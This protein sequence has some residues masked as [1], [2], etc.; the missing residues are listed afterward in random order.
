MNNRCAELVEQICPDELSGSDSCQLLP[1]FRI[2]HCVLVLLSLPLS[3][4]PSPSLSVSL[5]V[6]MRGRHGWV[7]KHGCRC[8]PSEMPSCQC[9]IY[10][11]VGRVVDVYTLASCARMNEWHCCSSLCHESPAVSFLFFKLCNVYPSTRWANKKHCA[12]VIVAIFLVSVDRFRQFFCPHSRQWSAHVWNIFYHLTLIALPHYRVK[13]ERVRFVKTA[14]LYLFSCN[15]KDFAVIRYCF[16]LIFL[17]AHS[18][19]QMT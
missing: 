8:I 19:F 3:L 12:T 18:V 2:L 4:S 14:L 5:C 10:S 17:A 9:K 7:V 11:A 1:G 13:C 6:R 15:K 16:W